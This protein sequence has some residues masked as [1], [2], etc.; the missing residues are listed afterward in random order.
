LPSSPTAAPSGANPPQTFELENGTEVDL[1]PLAD[2]LCERYYDIYPDDLERYGAAGRAWLEHDS[3]YLL[4]WGL[5]DARA[6]MVDCVEQVRW[7]GRV[8]ANRSFPI[9]RLARRVELT[10]AV[11]R[12]SGLG[13]VGDRA[14]ARMA[15]AAAALVETQPPGVTQ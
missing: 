8:L 7:L 5:E 9:Q 12:S 11:T 10:A 13:E 4:A 15:Q 3:R 6:G 2:Q 1:G 14:A